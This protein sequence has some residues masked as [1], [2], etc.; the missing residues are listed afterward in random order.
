MFAVSQS[1]CNNAAGLTQFCVINNRMNTR[2][3]VLV[4]LT[5]NMTSDV[6]NDQRRSPQSLHGQWP[7]RSS[8]PD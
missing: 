1:Y 6:S 7:H 5:L 4:Q 8:P 3:G 2:Y